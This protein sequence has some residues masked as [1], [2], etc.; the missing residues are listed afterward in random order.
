MPLIILKIKITN[1]FTDTT[2]NNFNVEVTLLCFLNYLKPCNDQGVY[3]FLLHN[4]NNLEINITKHLT[5]T[6]NNL[7]VKITLLCFLS[8]LKPYNDQ[9]TYIFLL[10]NVNNSELTI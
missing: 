7:N 3:I 1:H 6:K 9:V 5:D 2:K 8:Y 4:I 10:H